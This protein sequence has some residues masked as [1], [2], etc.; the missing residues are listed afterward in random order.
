MRAC[1]AALAG[2]TV[3]LL[4][5]AGQANTWSHTPGVAEYFSRG[6]FLAVNCTD[7]PRAARPRPRC[8]PPF[9][10][11]EW[12]SVSGF[13]QP[14]D[15]CDRWPKPLRRPPAVPSRKLGRSVP[16]LIIGGDLDSLTPIA[17]APAIARAVGGD[18]T[19]ITVPNTVH[20]TSQGGNYLVAGGRCARSY[21][22]TFLKGRPPV[23]TCTGP[24]LYQPPGYP[25][26][27]DQAPLASVI[28]GPD[29]GERIRRLATIAREA[30]ADAVGRWIYTSGNRGPGL[31]GGG[32]T[33]DDGRD[34]HARPA[35]AS[36]PTSPVSGRP[37]PATAATGIC[38]SHDRGHQ[39]VVRRERCRHA[40][41]SA[42]RFCTCTPPRRVRGMDAF[43]AIVSRREVREYDGREL[44]EE[45][46]RRILEAGRLAGSSRNRQQRRFVVFSDRAAASRRTS[47]NAEQHPRR[48]ARR[49]DRHRPARARSRW[50][51]AAPPRT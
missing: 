27:L 40:P 36:S 23:P 10:P 31:R 3:P 15:V 30:F 21:I 46:V 24:T 18:A 9:T 16:V 14:Y 17:D 7:L 13:T 8:L 35:C 41:A 22:R 19:I 44:P 2:D 11:A 5:L 29:P 20:V 12:T 48:R 38:P 6:A 45:A 50:T 39:R 51:P 26:A 32:F 28:A 42:T 34:V 43:L 47:I 25:P 4:R 1:S 37:A 49:R 33:V